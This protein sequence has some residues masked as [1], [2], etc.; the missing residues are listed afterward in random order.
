MITESNRWNSL[1]QYW[2]EIVWS[3]LQWQ[4]IKALIRVE[5]NFNPT[6]R[7]KAGAIGLMQLMPLTA[8]EMGCHDPFNPDENL[9]A[10][11]NYLKKQFGHF[12]E[13]PLLKERLKFA[14]AAYVC[15]R[16]N[17]NKAIK[18]AYAEEFGEA[19]PPDHKGKNGQWQRWNYTV[20]FF[21]GIISHPETVKT[22][23]IDIWYFYNTFSWNPDEL[24]R[25]MP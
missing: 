18:A 2:T 17:V 21:G 14:Q 6:A 10:G 1:I 11:I 3:P 22:Y 20:N 16:G 25:E 7:S 4:M 5:S 13:I 23:V 8:N 9:E 24:F 15:G 19:I 12:L